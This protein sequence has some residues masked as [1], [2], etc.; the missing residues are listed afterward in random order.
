MNSSDPPVEGLPLARIPLGPGGEFDLIRQLLGSESPLPPGVLV[1]PGDDCTVL[2]GGIVVSADLTVEDVHF[3]REWITLREAGY[4]ATA[5]ALSDLAAMAA[6]PFGVL[7]SLAVGPG[8]PR[9]EAV[10]LQTGAR[11][12]CERE[13]IAI[14]GGDLTGS[15]GPV[16]MDVVVL[17]RSRAPILRSGSLPGHE[18]WVTGWMG[19]SG[20]AV[21]LWS[22]GIVP[23]E[24][25]R[26]TFVRPR[27]RI[28][29]ALWLAKRAP[30]RSLVDISDGLVGDAGHLA[31]A[32]GVSV[33]LEES[34][35]PLHPDLEEALVGSGDAP[36]DVALGGGEDYE[37]C[38][39]VPPGSMRDLAEPFAETFGIPLTRVG[40]V[41]E[42][43]DIEVLVKT[44][45]GM[46]VS[47]KR[48]GFS[49]FTE[50]G[51]E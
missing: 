40:S 47:P 9:L 43:A 20:A 44:R 36:L 37:L 12:A 4:R 2:E 23:R 51:R 41:V 10:E 35:I 5:A 24:S 31:A 14:L 29:E 45:R 34:A 30:L 50:K 27:P 49:H 6:E 3:R 33:V 15:P 38:F 42:R 32:A 22:R 1:G 25:I 11:E 19:G 26:E 17:G 46:M 13:G 7:L 16:A 8:N 21:A 28:R 18:V 39:T 48:R